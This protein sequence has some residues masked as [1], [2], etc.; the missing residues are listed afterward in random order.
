MYKLFVD[1]N[2]KL[3][4]FSSDLLDTTLETLRLKNGDEIIA[5]NKSK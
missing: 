4:D 1:T 3:I 5:E 2:P